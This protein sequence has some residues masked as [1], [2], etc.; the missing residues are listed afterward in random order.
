MLFSRLVV[1]QKGG[2]TAMA[3]P[4][5]VDIRLESLSKAAREQLLFILAADPNRDVRFTTSGDST[6]ATL[7]SISTS[8][9]AFVAVAAHVEPV[10]SLASNTTPRQPY[11]LRSSSRDRARS[12]SRGRS[13]SP[14]GTA[15][16]PS[17]LRRGEKRTV[18]WASRLVEDMMTAVA[19]VGKIDRYS[20]SDVADY[21]RHFLAARSGLQ[22]IVHETHT[23]II[24]ATS[25][26]KPWC[27]ACRVFDDCLNQ[28][29]PLDAF[30]LVAKWR[31]ELNAHTT[32]EAQ[33]VFANDLGPQVVLRRYF[34]LHAVPNL[35]KL[36]TRDME[37]TRAQR[38]KAALV[39][40]L[41]QRGT[42]AASSPAALLQ[43][44]DNDG[45]VDAVELL[46]V[47]AASAGAPAAR[48]SAFE[49]LKPRHVDAN[50]MPTGKPDPWTYAW[51]PR[52][53]SD[54]I[55][56]VSP[57][58]LSSV[59]EQSRM[60]SPAS[61]VRSDRQLESH[62]AGLSSPEDSSR[63]WRSDAIQLRRRA[64]ADSLQS[65]RESGP[66][67]LKAKA[68]P[69]T[70]AGFSVP[71]S[72]RK[73]LGNSSRWEQSILTARNRI[74]S[75]LGQ[76]SAVKTDM[77]AEEADLF[78]QLQASL[79]D[80]AQPVRTHAFSADPHERTHLMSPTPLERIAAN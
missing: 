59:H 43:A 26:F 58:F 19:K 14:G 57:R 65:E 9:P 49:P 52:E 23:D 33:K 76:L 67:P 4:R 55:L 54:S 22:S 12:R 15:A 16:G 77:T 64:P 32:T 35:V 13:P 56:P 78:G 61:T 51:G 8:H 24:N 10:A 6:I 48:P 42:L 38:L 29:Y 50:A 45:F 70:S 28:R 34:P 68:P 21:M 31:V 30:E 74:D 37:R 63:P 7:T 69:P 5:V 71:P 66:S 2:E 62:G 25:W 36:L 3:V 79:A 72:V 75:A 27:P 44:F 47:A 80:H 1:F 60:L 41:N 73:P 18:Q 17:P 40:F 46:R 11:R 53:S 20:Y 39:A